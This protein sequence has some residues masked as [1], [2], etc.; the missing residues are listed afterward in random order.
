MAQRSSEGKPRKG[1]G[2]V[3]EKANK[4]PS[5]LALVASTVGSLSASRQSAFLE[6]MD[7]LV[8]TFRELLDGKIK[9]VSLNH[10]AAW[11]SLN[12]KAVGFVD[13]GVANLQGIGA[14]PVAIRVGT[15]VVRPGIS[16][17]SRERF[18]FT[19]H[20]IGELFHT[21]FDE[22]DSEAVFDEPSEME[23]KMRDAAR[24]I[25]EASGTLRLV[26]KQPDL[27]LVFVH[28]PLVNPVAPY[29]D[30]PSLSKEAVERLTDEKGSDKEDDRHFIAVYKGILDRLKDT[31]VPMAGII[32]R[33]SSKSL[34]N[35]ILGQ[36]ESSMR[37]E[38]VGD[39]KTRLKEFGINDALLFSFLLEAGEYL[40]FQPID[41]NLRAKAPEKWEDMIVSYP[42][43]LTTILKATQTSF[44]F[45]VE[46]WPKTPKATTEELLR[47]TY[48][49]A[50]LLP[51][52][53]FPVGIDI[54]DKFA[55]F[56][57]W[58]SNQLSR[59]MAATLLRK[60][61]ETGDPETIRQVQ[62]LLSSR[63]RDWFFRPSWSE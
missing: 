11:A 12:G 31:G 43:P 57:A 22:E 32:E 16:G 33:S 56:P 27:S 29:A 50:R 17:P 13:G 37:P 39:I 44:P 21:R 53:A 1:K 24:M 51:R 5:L 9:K 40:E 52:Y 63:S 38:E 30:I 61:L 8:E 26:E 41:K 58:L 34:M 35:S 28:G 42:H 55:K 25:T 2:K 48:H 47:V 49:M 62:M 18:T 23:T 20:L 15:Y 45:R 10:A 7:D 6:E 3:R 59:E 60:A 36:H 46:T 14:A 19:Q 54:A 4:E